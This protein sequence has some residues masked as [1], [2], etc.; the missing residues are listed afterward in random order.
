M[1]SRPAVPVSTGT[2]VF[3]L[4]LLVR[5]VAAIL[6]T[7][8][9]VNPEADGDAVAFAADAARIAS[10]L[11]RGETPALYLGDQL[12]SAMISPFWLLP[13]PSDL[14]ARLGTALLGAV[15]VYNVYLLARYH[16]S[17]RAGVVAA[18]PVLLYPSFVAVHSTLL[19]EAAVLFGIT[20]AAQLL[21]VPRPEVDRTRRYGLAFLAIAFATVLRADNAPIYLA[22][23]LA[24]LGIRLFQQRDVPRPVAYGLVGLAGAG[25]ALSLSL[26]DRAIGFLAEV[27]RERAI[28]RTAYLQEVVPETVLE[29]VAFSWIGA[30]YFLFAPFP[31]MVSTPADL[32]VGLEGMI[33]LLYAVAAVF[34]V[35]ALLHRAP[36]AA[37][38][39]LV[40]LLLGSVLYG[41]G[42][43]NFGTA[44]RHRQMFLWIVFVF[45]AVGVA[46]RVRFR[47]FG[48]P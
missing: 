31:W 29:L 13:G 48:D 8:F 35:R 15:A 39:L 25:V 30:A 26:A 33:S 42:T 7:L 37:L 17:Q 46:E 18:L 23:V 43:A 3:G 16:H 45:G 44:M 28:G 47:A 36:A 9:P 40:G 21:L 32:V 38:A 12:W 1:N 22:A 19:R 2:L 10:G 27:R 5:V 41:V 24:F 6:T 4:A 20:T 34:G 14:Y 11:A